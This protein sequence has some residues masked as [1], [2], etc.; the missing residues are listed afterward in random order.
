MEIIA[1][2]KKAYYDYA[3][4]EEFNAGIVLKGNEVKT[5][6]DKSLSINGAYCFVDNDEVF[7]KN[8]E[9][10]NTKPKVYSIHDEKR[11]KKLLLKKS[12][13][14]KISKELINKSTT[15]VPLMLY[16]NDRGLA[17]LK[18]AVCRSKRK[19]EKRESIKLKDLKKSS[20]LFK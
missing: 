2:N 12:E 8:L 18:I 11:D 5:L 4:I 19:Y 3:I 6:R 13:I 14:K 9:L 7:I 15:I 1:N 20:N 16:F 17:K 10:I